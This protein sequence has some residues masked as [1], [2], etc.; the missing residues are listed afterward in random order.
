MR[1]TWSA[2][3]FI[4]DLAPPL[5]CLAD[6]VGPMVGAPGASEH[7]GEHAGEHAAPCTA[8]RVDPDRDVLALVEAG[9]VPAALRHLMRRHGAAV[10]RYCR[11]AL[12]A[13][14]LA[15]DVHQQVFIEAFRDL[16][17]FRGRSNVRTWLFAIAR[18]RVLDAAKT[19][20]RAQ[21][22]LEETDPW[23]SQI[24]GPRPTRRSMTRG[25]A[26]HS[27]RAWPSSARPPGLPSSCATSKDSRSR[28]WPRSAARSPARSTRASL[29]RFRCS[30]PA[31]RLAWA[32]PAE[33]VSMRHDAT[34]V[35]AGRRGPPGQ[36]PY[37]R[38]MISR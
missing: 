36:P 19:R 10:Y 27:S 13:T 6:I 16:P 20:K 3:E 12:R 31:S 37:G 35:R 9:D 11:E 7:A 24:H 26:R 23:R 33:R 29:A 25:C 4:R 1:M 14:A 28:R 32:S 17:K 34:N 18:N 30:A 38:V 15:D 8:R 2:H 21:A 22:H 5:P